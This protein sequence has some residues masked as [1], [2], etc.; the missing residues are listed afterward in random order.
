MNSVGYSKVEKE[1]KERTG[2]MVTRLQLKNKWNKLK[3]DFKVCRK[4]KLRETMTSWDHE[5]GTIDMNDD[6]WKKARAVSV[7]SYF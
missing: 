2:L 5:K 6:W 1:F 7:I 3:E 4:L